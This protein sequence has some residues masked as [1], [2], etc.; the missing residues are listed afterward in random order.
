L[1]ALKYKSKQDFLEASRDIEELDKNLF[2][3]AHIHSFDYKI[4]DYDILEKALHIQ[5]YLSIS[6]LHRELR[7]LDIVECN[8]LYALRINQNVPIKIAPGSVD[9]IQDF[10]NDKDIPYLIDDQLSPAYSI[11]YDFSNDEKRDYNDYSVFLY[12]PVSQLKNFEKYRQDTD[13]YRLMIG[14]QTTNSKA[15]QKYHE[16]ANG[17][18]TNTLFHYNGKEYLLVE[19]G[20]TYS[21][22]FSKDFN[23]A[24][25]GY[26]IDNWKSRN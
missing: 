23:F 3:L 8:G 20:H 14:M 10:S 15:G 22:N 24:L 18:I 25:L 2:G 6:N 13:K 7:Q 4:L 9:S 26:C 21:M 16:E 5:E 12:F 1:L 19:S 17:I 11:S